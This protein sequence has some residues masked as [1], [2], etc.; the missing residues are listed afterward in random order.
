MRAVC[1]VK[2]LEFEFSGNMF[3]NAI[4]LGDA[5]NDG[6][7]E[8]TVG[9]MNG[10]LAIF[11][12]N[13]CVQ[14]I[15]GLGMITA[16]G[17]GDILNC[18]SNVLV[19]ISG[20]GWCHIY[21][22]LHPKTEENQETPSDVKLEPVHIQRIP[23]NTK[24]IL[25]ADIEGDGN[26]EL[27]MG[28]TDRVVRSYRWV[29]S[30]AGGKLVCLNK[31]EC[32][33]QIGTVVL[34]HGADG[35]PYLL[36]AQPGGT[37]M[38]IRSYQSPA[39]EN[40]NG[41]TT[42]E[43]DRAVS[44]ESA[45]SHV[46]YHPLT[47]SRMRN[48]N[49]STEIVGDIEQGSNK[50]ADK[51]N[52][53]AVATLDGTLMFIQDEEIIWS[54]QV[55]HQ[56]FALSKLDITGDGRDEIIACSWDGQTYMLDQEKNSVRFQLEESVSCFCAGLYTLE[57][58]KPPVPC[59]IYT[60]F[61]NKIFVYYDVKLPSMLTKSVITKIKEKGELADLLGDEVVSNKKAL[62]ELVSWCLYGHK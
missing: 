43:S 28:L 21:L 3:Q 12:R 45:P 30:A 24:Q 4:A 58:G 35:S 52:P 50:S 27:V 49:I 51:G 62:Q 44:P 46:D 53:Y 39:T 37:F 56:L 18:K 15:T 40:G 2:R 34:N 1:F 8:L 23:A 48:P 22:C 7:I 54:I 11:K 32:A 9:N 31:W 55:D 17:I 60:T 59:I 38:R 47:S 16:I 29:K 13:Q 26:V 36:V 6:E 57:A 41:D 33:N 5:D 42:E 61:T 14:K 25:L 19:V 10:D 20:D